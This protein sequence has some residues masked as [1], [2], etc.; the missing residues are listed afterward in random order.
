MIVRIAATVA[1]SNSMRVSARKPTAF[2][3]SSTS[4]TTAPTPYCHSNRNQM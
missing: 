2:V 1:R 4:V 3:T